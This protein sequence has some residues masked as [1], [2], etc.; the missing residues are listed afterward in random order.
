MSGTNQKPEPLEKRLFRNKRFAF[1]WML[2]LAAFFLFVSWPIRDFLLVCWVYGS[3]AFFNHSVRVV[4][5][6]PTR[7][8]DGA[9]APTLPNL[10]TGFGAFIV[11]MLG[12]TLLLIAILRFYE[13]H[14]QRR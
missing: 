12:L 8:S 4:S 13:R 7:F 6:K 10:V 14:S 1:S 3:S 5:A 11:T 2:F 9:L